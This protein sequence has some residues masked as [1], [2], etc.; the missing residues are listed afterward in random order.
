MLAMMQLHD[1]SYT[2]AN[3]MSSTSVALLT[4]TLWLTCYASYIVRPIFRPILHEF[5]GLILAGVFIFTI[6]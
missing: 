5:E 2:S 1:L 6:S 4:R 3:T